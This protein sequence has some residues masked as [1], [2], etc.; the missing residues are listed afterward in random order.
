MPQGGLLISKVLTRIGGLGI[1]AR[2]PSSV[3]PCHFTGDPIP[4]ALYPWGPGH[5]V[6]TAAFSFVLRL[7]IQIASFSDFE[8][9]LSM[10]LGLG[11]IFPQN[12]TGQ[13]K[14]LT[15]SPRLEPVPTPLICASRVW[16]WGSFPF[17]DLG[18]LRFQS[19]QYRSAFKVYL[20]VFSGVFCFSGAF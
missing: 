1:I 3:L 18:Y 5:V 17:P 12:T 8:W 4:A 10:V 19:T 14:L 9:K 11:R 7:S 20:S 6:S 16:G 15:T 2:A 13:L